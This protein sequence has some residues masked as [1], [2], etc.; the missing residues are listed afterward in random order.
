[1]AELND[2]VSQIM[3]HRLDR[4]RP[5]WELWILTGLEHG[6][7]AVV[8]KI[9]HCLADGAATV[10]YLSR[11]F[12]QQATMQAGSLSLKPWQPQPLPTGR[13]L[14]SG[15][16]RDHI[17]KDIRQFPAFL[18]VLWRASGRLFTFHRDVGSPTLTR[19]TH[20]PPRTRFNHTLSARR[21]FTT[22][23]IPLQDVKQ[24]AHGLEASVNDMVLAMSAA[25][26]RDYLLFH[27]DLPNA[28]LCTAIPVSADELGS[29][30]ESGNRTT[31]LPT[32]LWTNIA[33]SRERFTAIQRATRLGKQELDLLG[34]TTFIQLMQFIPPLFSVW[35]TNL[36]QRRRAPDKDDYRPM[37]NVII[38][39]VSGP[40]E[41]VSGNYGTLVDIYS[42]GP[43]I[44]GCG[45]NITVW[46]YAG[47]LNF[48][49]MGCKKSVPD[50]E[51]LADGLFD[52][53]VDLQRMCADNLEV[54]NDGARL[55][56]VQ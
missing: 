35:K 9:H 37:T 34:K 39:N 46:S 54:R 2:M 1:M 23:Q 47:N 26:I 31:Y 21:S 40:P 32:C 38:S 30:R 55:E 36:K 17:K 18:A 6:R 43:L 22:R 53:L 13:A 29:N 5:M 25:T 8:H 42:M 20:P 7:V 16:V 12:E 24:I 28:P 50:I 15:A 48:S 49:L 33:D 11:V 51:R 44:E 45:L 27:G 52:A 56:T 41:K 4:S 14:L 3:C 19:L 10:R